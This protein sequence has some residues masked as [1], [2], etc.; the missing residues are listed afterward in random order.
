MDIELANLEVVKPAVVFQQQE[1]APYISLALCETFLLI[2]IVYA[3][4]TK[5]QPKVRLTKV[6]MLPI[7]S[8]LITGLYITVMYLGFILHDF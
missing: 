2:M 4:K 6:S 7:Y 1:W 3:A 8:G 5:F